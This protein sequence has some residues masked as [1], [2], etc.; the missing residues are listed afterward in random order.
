MFTM[1][2]CVAF[3]LGLGLGLLSTHVFARTYH[4]A[5]DG[6]D[7]NPGTRHRPLSTIQRAVEMAGAGDVVL[8]YPGEY[9]GFTV[10]SVHAT[11]AER[12]VFKGLPGAVINQPGP[13]PIDPPLNTASDTYE[14]TVWPHAITIQR[15]E[16]V[17]VEGFEV[18]GMP[19]REFDEADEL[20][21]K[22]G[23][24]VYAEASR[25]LTFR[26]NN[27]HDNGRW[28]LFTAFCDDTVAEFN[29]ASGS[30]LEHGIYL[31]NSADRAIVRGNRV[32]GN[33]VSGIQ[34]NADNAF[35]NADYRAFADPDGVSQFNVIVG[36]VIFG[37]GASGG[38]AI[39]LDGVSD[40]LIQHNYLYD[41]HAT[42]IALYQI[43]GRTGSQRNRVLGNFV[44][45][46]ADGRW[47]L[48]ILGCTPDITSDGICIEATAPRLPEWEAL[49]PIGYASASTGN[50]VE[51]NVLISASG[52]NGAII[53]D[54]LSLEADAE[55]GEVFTSDY[56]RLVDRFALNAETVDTE[57]E[58]LSGLEWRQRTGQDA[59]SHLLDAVTE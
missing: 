10:D 16:Y 47:A 37:N 49:R 1:P 15:S 33:A 31:S 11:H 53:T 9:S 24:G 39:N 13:M 52:V 29:F 6:S 32:F 38:A 42:G 25:H 57:P 43:N 44:R 58:V 26:R 54:A 46:P 28:G 3:S 14:W 45:M 36:N 50:F 51:H 2:R 12:L 30:K 27:F 19:G 18:T 40:S 35:D 56:N 17:T 7:G 22:G 5:T 20:L 8:V 48:S 41:N 55:S 21:H 59:H 23:A 34:I 4:V